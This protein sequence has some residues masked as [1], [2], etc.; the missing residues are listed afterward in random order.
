MRRWLFVIGGVALIGLAGLYAI[1]SFAMRPEAAKI[2]PLGAIEQRFT[3]GT[4]DNVSL[5]ASYF[6]GTSPIAPG[7]V[8]LHGIKSSRGQFVDEVSWLTKAGFAVLAIDF[9]G[10]GESQ[11]LARSFGFYEA[12]DAHAAVNW[13]R[14]KQQGAPIG[15]IGFSLGGAAALLGDRGPVR[16]DA[17]VLDA[18]YPDIHAAIRNRIALRAGDTL[19][20]LGEPLLSYQSYV[21]FGTSPDALSPAKALSRFKGPTLMIGG[22]ED[23]YTS[24]AEVRAMAQKATQLEDVWIIPGQ[25]HGAVSSIYAPEYQAR[26]LGFFEKHLIKQAK[27]R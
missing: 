9:R 22:A 1:G 2:P 11:Q 5:A 21:R 4:T 25:P 20:M 10:H 27:V 23:V 3:L 24:P 8:L 26:I 6:A 15:V 19:A 7:I 16:A 12:R 17:L 13:L 18:V 14:R